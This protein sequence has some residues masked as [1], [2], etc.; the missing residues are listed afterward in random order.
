M[1]VVGLTAD[2]TGLK[3]GIWIGF[4]K[5]VDVEFFVAM[6]EMGGVF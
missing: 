5:E 6:G 3:R 1:G 2:F 4:S